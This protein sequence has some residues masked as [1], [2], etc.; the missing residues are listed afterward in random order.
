MPEDLY[1]CSCGK[2]FKTAQGLAGHRRFCEK[3]VDRSGAKESL[4]ELAQ[5][6]SE[7]EEYHQGLVDAHKGT[8]KRLEPQVFGPAN[9]AALTEVRL[10]QPHNAD[11]WN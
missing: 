2:G 11:L 3:G 1:R 6:L 10:Q 5:R 9:I 8:A 7:L 4:A